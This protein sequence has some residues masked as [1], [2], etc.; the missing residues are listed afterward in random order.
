VREKTFQRSVTEEATKLCAI[1]LDLVPDLEGQE[2][3]G[4]VSTNKIAQK[5][6]TIFNSTKIFDNEYR[7]YSILLE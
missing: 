6:N 7:I 1:I 4:P 2:V 3:N 5:S